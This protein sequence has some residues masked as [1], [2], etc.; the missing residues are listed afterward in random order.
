M[1]HFGL[2]NLGYVQN[3]EAK[4]AKFILQS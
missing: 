3:V 1:V 4:L 2:K